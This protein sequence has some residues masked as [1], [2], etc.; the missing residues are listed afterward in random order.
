M[1]KRILAILLCLFMLALLCAC[2]A[3][4]GEPSSSVPGESTIA[5]SS[6]VS[7]EISIE[8]SSILEETSLPEVSQPDESEPEISEPE[9]SQPEI[10]EPEVSE[11][12]VSDPPSRSFR[13]KRSFPWNWRFG[14]IWAPVIRSA[15]GRIPTVIRNSGS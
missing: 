11:P 4:D 6:E 7:E 8:E 3:E 13:P 1:K 12:E 10:S 15:C 9:K 5:S 2:T 14:L